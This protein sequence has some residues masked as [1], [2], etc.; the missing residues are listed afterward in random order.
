MALFRTG[1]RRWPKWTRHITLL[2]GAM[3]GGAAMTRG[4]PLGG[5]TACAEHHSSQGRKMCAVG[6]LKRFGKMWPETGWGNA[7]MCRKCQIMIQVMC[8]SGA[9]ILGESGDGWGS[10]PSRCQA[11][12]LG[13]ILKHVHQRE[14]LRMI[15][16]IGVQGR[17]LW[18]SCRQMGRVEAFPVDGCIFLRVQSIIPWCE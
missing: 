2:L 7:T 14:E 5:S 3:A 1:G 6:T 8:Y 16:A 12:L 18:L 17:R 15:S 4:A 9:R 11:H 13:P 10:G